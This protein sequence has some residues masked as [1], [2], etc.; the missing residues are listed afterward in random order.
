MIGDKSWREQGCVPC[1]R[2]ERVERQLDRL[3]VVHADLQPGPA[4]RRRSNFSSAV[5]WF[6]FCRG[7][8]PVASVFGAVTE[9]VP[10]N[11]VTLRFV[12]FGN[13]SWDNLKN[14]FQTQGF[15]FLFL[16]QRALRAAFGG[17]I[18][19]KMP[20][21]KLD[22]S[23]AYR[24]SAAI[25]SE[26]ARASLAPFAKPQVIRFSYCSQRGIVPGGY[27]MSFSMIDVATSAPCGFIYLVAKTGIARTMLSPHDVR[28]CFSLDLVVS[29]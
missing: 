29:R 14:S 28:H 16:S 23:L 25:A 7:V 10:P 17:S 2:V 19:S 15:E 12:G 22:R 6:Q 26:L 3:P 18:T 11:D 9:R 4:W 5:P 20:V 27:L 21:L 13:K 8:I 24:L 1:S